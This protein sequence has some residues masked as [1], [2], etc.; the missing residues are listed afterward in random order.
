MEI[1][2]I[3]QYIDVAQLVL[4]A[5]WIFFFL[6][7]IYIRKE[8]KR[9][10]YPLV[11][12]RR[13]GV[14]VVGFPAPPKP[15]TF[16]L[17]HGG[18]RTVPREDDERPVAA[19][20][21][22][23]W[24]G[25]PLDPTGDPMLDGV[26]PASYAMREQTPDLTSEGK[27]KIVPL[28]ITDEYSVAAEDPDPR[29]MRVLDA[30]QEMAGTVKDLWLDKSDML[31]RYLEVEPADHSSNVLIP[32]SLTR[33]NSITNTVRVIAVSAAQLAQGPRLQ[34]PDSVTFREEDQIT[35]YYAGGHLFAY[36]SRR[37]PLL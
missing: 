5:F 17:F 24:P 10:G 36:P 20:P 9:E 7:I 14:S 30:K 32:M 11:S 18:T 35:A 12:D 3:T 23:K 15:K 6:L 19:E 33:I 26:G 1:G 13:G 28:R 29:G 21:V 27:Q 22:A 25:A 4:Y 37:E 31:F 8:D 16:R 2:S 34:T